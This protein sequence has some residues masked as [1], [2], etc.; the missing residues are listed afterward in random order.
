MSYSSM[1][2][3]RCSMDEWSL[4]T[5]GVADA[6]GGVPGS[7]NDQIQRLLNPDRIVFVE[8]YDSA[9][10]FAVVEVIL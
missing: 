2:F 1:R 8:V 6:A 3:A 4:P 7:W 9:Q 5:S 10:R